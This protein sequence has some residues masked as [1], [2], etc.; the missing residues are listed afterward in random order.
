[1]PPIRKASEDGLE[2]APIGQNPLRSM[3]TE[4][5]NIGL[6]IDN[7]NDSVG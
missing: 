5:K 7:D 4:R 3:Q 6:T 2:K 1:M